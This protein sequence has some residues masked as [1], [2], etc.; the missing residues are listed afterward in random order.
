[1]SKV[2]KVLPKVVLKAADTSQGLPIPW[3]GFWTP[4]LQVAVQVEN[5]AAVVV[6]SADGGLP[7]AAEAE[8]PV[9]RLRLIGVQPHVVPLGFRQRQQAC[10]VAHQAAPHL[11][12]EAVRTVHP[13]PEQRMSA[14]STR[15]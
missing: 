6:H 15:D 7:S 4:A 14:N 3:N 8:G 9:E 1:M 11:Q 5:A 13:E 2:A 12:L 10:H